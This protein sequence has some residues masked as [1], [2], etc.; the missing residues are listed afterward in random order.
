MDQDGSPSP[1][2]LSLTWTLCAFANRWIVST[3]VRHPCWTAVGD[4]TE[5][6]EHDRGPREGASQRQGI[7]HLRPI[8]LQVEA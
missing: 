3:P 1:K 6:I 7:V 8:E 5:M 4:H 2:P